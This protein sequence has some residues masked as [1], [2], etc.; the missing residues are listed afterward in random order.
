VFP[1][2]D[3]GINLT[4][5]A[6]TSST[7]WTFWIEAIAPSTS[8][9]D[10][11]Y[12]LTR[13][14]E[15][16]DTPVVDT[17]RATAVGVDLDVDSN[18]DGIIDPRNDADGTDDPIEGDASKGLVIPVYTG[19]SD[20]DGQE[21]T[22][23]FD[24]IV[25]L[26]FAPVN[27]GLS[28][29]A[30]YAWSK[31]IKG[32]GDANEDL[33][34]LTFTFTFSD[35][36][37]GSAADGMFRLWTKDAPLAR[38]EADLIRASVPIPASVLFAGTPFTTLEDYLNNYGTT[39]LYLEVL[40]P[41]D[42]FEPITVTLG[43]TGAWAFSA[44][45]DL[46]HARGVVLDLDLDVD[47]NNDE[48]FDLPSQTEWEDKLE[49][50]PYAIGKLVMQ[51][52]W[53]FGSGESIAEDRLADR[54]TP[55]FVELPKNLP[56]DGKTIGVKFDM[57]AIGALQSGEIQLWTRDKGPDLRFEDAAGQP[58][59]SLPW[60]VYGDRVYFNKSYTL[61]QINY[62]P[63]T[64]L[65]ILYMDGHTPTKY[66]TLHD[67]ETHMRSSGVLQATLTFDT[68]NERVSLA[69]DSIQYVV[70]RDDFFY[71]DFQFKPE[72]RS[73]LASIGVYAHAD[74]PH[75]ALQRLSQQQLGGLLGE[76]ADPAIAGMLYTN[77]D[78]ET[79]PG[80]KAVLYQDFA[81]KENNTLLLA[82]AGTDDTAGEFYDGKGYDWAENVW[83]GLGFGSFQY[84]YAMQIATAVDGA[85]E[86]LIGGAFFTTTGHSLGGGLASAASVVTGAAGITFNAAGLH[87][88]TLRQFLQDPIELDAALQRYDHAGGLITAF[89]VDHDFLTQAQTLGAPFGIPTALGAPEMRD[90]PYDL[91]ALIAGG[92]SILVPGPG[93][94]LGAVWFIAVKVKAHLMPAM[95]WGL[96]VQEGI[97]GTPTRDTLGYDASRF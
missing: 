76:D 60:D 79:Y 90:G 71:H 87:T 34:G 47:S 83:Q 72:V 2:G 12:T 59:P 30:A 68:P 74:M 13:H 22:A 23:D 4:A 45:S 27:L 91:E 32:E 50:H 15:S 97:T 53:K 96:L 54:F 14:G 3:S 29:G 31:P 88:N 16:S 44:T 7:N 67:V 28:R 64:G 11:A 78:A 18:N 36:G 82:F 58:D 66:V 69:Q 10:I 24:G 70:I 37:L 73:A 35:A 89:H 42:T 92:V 95:L 65:A 57:N 55:V 21:D 20:G 84:Q 77:L 25:G 41:S 26:A 94:V 80:F 49:D 56:V 5:Q 86:G 38:T 17:V 8:L 46:V 1:E 51:S 6:G 62:D 81:A 93:G 75:A 33:P 85:M 61:S 19:D 43:G 39:T 52:S 9:A 40:L 63:A 48:G